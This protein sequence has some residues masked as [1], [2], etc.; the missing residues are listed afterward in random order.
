[1]SS[2]LKMTVDEF[3]KVVANRRDLYEACVR[4]GY[5]LPKIKTTMVTEDYMLR[6][7][8]APAASGRPGSGGR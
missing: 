3:S 6:V 8:A 5:Y 1:M 7:I 2:K 4:N